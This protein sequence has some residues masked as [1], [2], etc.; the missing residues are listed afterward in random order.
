VIIELFPHHAPRCSLG[1]VAVKLIFWCL[2]EGFQRLT[3]AARIDT[4]AG[5]DTQPAKRPAAVDEE[6]AR[7]QVCDSFDLCFIICEFILYSHDSSVHKKPSSVDPSKK[8]AQ[9]TPS[10]Y[11]TPVA[12]FV[13]VTGSTMLSAAEVWEF[14][15]G[16]LNF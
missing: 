1:L 6:N 9:L 12:P 3:Q 14:C 5:T 8:I 11:A 13:G 2:F 16:Q 10:S 15:W 4:S 7:A